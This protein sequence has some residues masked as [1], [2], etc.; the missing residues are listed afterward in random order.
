MILEELVREFAERMRGR[1]YTFIGSVATRAYGVFK[2]ETRDMDV[3]TQG[4]ED[5]E[6]ACLSMA[7][8]GLKEAKPKGGFSP[9][10]AKWKGEDIGADVM[11]REIW[12]RAELGGGVE[13]QRIVTDGEF[14]RSI[15][16]EGRETLGFDVP[17]PSPADLAVLKA[18]S[19]A[20]PFRNPFKGAR[21]R[22]QALELIRRFSIPHERLRDRARAMGCTEF[23][24]S[25]LAGTGKPASRSIF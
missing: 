24:E 21:D 25:F 10:F 15:R 19:S 8:M 4:A 7:G 1:R 22:E 6:A 14:W 23:V 18:A 17:V 9:G 16:Q 5:F 11:L 20:T 12:L 2:G 13:E 3:L